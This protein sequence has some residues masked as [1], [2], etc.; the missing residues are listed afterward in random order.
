MAEVN[1]FVLMRLGQSAYELNKDNSK[2]YLLK[3]Y[4]LEGEAIFED[5]DNKY[6]ESI[7]NLIEGK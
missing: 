4:M 6:L 2:E 3:A 5:Q 7:R 1:P